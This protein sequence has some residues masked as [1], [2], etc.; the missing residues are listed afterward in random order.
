MSTNIDVEKIMSE[1]RADIVNSGRDK[2]P[3]SFADQEAAAAN[4][5]KGES[6]EEAIDYISCNYEVQPYEV[7]RGNK[8]AVL[9]KKVIRKVTGFFILPIVRQQNTL[10]YYYYRVAETIS[11]VKT[12]NEELLKKIDVLEK[13]VAE[14]ENK[15][16]G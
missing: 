10:N 8:L 3:L 15:R 11:A 5:H 12:D 14:I 6:I 7:L 1:I 4:G 9:F 13:R 16:N 2:E